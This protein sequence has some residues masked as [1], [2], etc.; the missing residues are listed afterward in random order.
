[1][2]DALS[3]VNHGMD[4]IFTR[5][6]V[7]SAFGNEQH[8]LQRKERVDKNWGKWFK[9]VAPAVGVPESEACRLADAGVCYMLRELEIRDAFSEF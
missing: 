3:I 2:N 4:Y 9:A 1:M 7:A 8:E 6:I 5:P